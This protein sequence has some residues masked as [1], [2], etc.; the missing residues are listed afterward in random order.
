LI[1]NFG[2]KLQLAFKISCENSAS[3]LSC[4]KYRLRFYS[5]HPHERS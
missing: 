1:K 3:G 5:N 2:A 4:G